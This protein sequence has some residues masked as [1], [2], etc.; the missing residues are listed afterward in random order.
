MYQEELCFKV[1]QKVPAFQDTEDQAQ[2]EAGV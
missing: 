2:Q 1:A